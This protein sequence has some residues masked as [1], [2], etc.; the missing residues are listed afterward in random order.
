MLQ[1]SANPALVK[2]IYQ[3]CL[4]VIV[5]VIFQIGD[6]RVFIGAATERLQHDVF[7]IGPGLEDYG[8]QTLAIL[9]GVAT[10]RPP[11]ADGPV[12]G[13][14][15]AGPDTDAAFW[16]GIVAG[17]V[18]GIATVTGTARL[19][20]LGRPPAVIALTITHSLRGRV[21]SR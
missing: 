20:L 4:V 1:E 7:Y 8:P 10:A 13:A 15:G 12:I 9:A 11:L 19:A 16:G 18:L 3:L 17:L 5:A 14:L 6:A 21:R 2:F